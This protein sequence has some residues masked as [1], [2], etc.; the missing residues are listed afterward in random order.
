MS[1][2]L[3]DGAVI[4]AVILGILGLMWTVRRIGEAAGLAPEVQ[5]KL[6]HVAT[7]L[8]ALTF[9]LIFATP[10][11]VL[12]LIGL[13]VL[14]M[15]AL[16]SGIAAGHGLGDVL[17]GVERKSWGEVYL[18]AAIALLF[19]RSGEQPVLYVL[20]ILVVTL[21]DTAS[22]LVGTAYGRMRFAVEDGSKSLEGVVAFFVVTWLVA[23]IVL[24]LMTDAGRLNVIVLSAL[25]AAFCALVEAESWRGLD[26]LFVP[27]GA[28]LLLERHLDSG[29]LDLFVVSLLFVGALVTMLSLAP[30]IGLSRHSARAYTVLVFLI[31]SVTSPQNAVLPALAIA[32]H[33]RARLVRPCR[34]ERPDLD[35]LVCVAAVG[36]SWLVIGEALG[37]SAINLYNLTFAGAAIVFAGLAFSGSARFAAIPLA[38]CLGALFLWLAGFNLPGAARFTPGWPVAMVAVAIPSVIVLSWPQWF[39]RQ[40]SA[41]ALG[42]AL[43]VPVAICIRGV[44]Q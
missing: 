43:I 29:P 32:L 40:R 8:A 31:L 9:P 16:R 27:V 6:V 20:P 26:N 36:L 2:S 17:H 22:A 39:D 15:L 35:L 12:V 41:R 10:L 21:A 42:L 24:L 7:G 4:I 1:L 37:S 38:A 11:P 18:A 28:H 25:I 23:L 13:A 34:S 33:I 44:I 5:R 3:Q 30:A 19:L 14:V